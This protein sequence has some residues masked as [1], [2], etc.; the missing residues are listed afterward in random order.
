[1]TNAEYLIAIDKR[2]SRR[3]FK[4][5]ALDDD[6]KQLISELVDYVNEKAG[7]DFVFIDDARFAFNL[8][9]GMMSLIAV[10]G[11]D[12]IPA[13]QACGYYGET[14]VLQCAYHGIG[15]CWVGSYNEN[16]VLE[17]LDLPKGH[18][19]YCVIA[20]GNVSEKLSIK[21]K[22]IYSATHKNSKPYQK[23]FEFCDEKIT[24]EIVYAMQQVEKAP[25]S[26][27][28][29][30]VKFRYENG[31]VSAYVDEPYSDK[32][33]DFGIAQLHFQIGMS[34]KGVKG[35][36]EDG[37]FVA[38]TGRILKFPNAENSRNGVD[39]GNE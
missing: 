8:Q 32:S 4:P 29:R 11:P 15:T 26:V 9:S 18:R 20:V 37:R 3:A 1:M 6:V 7:L 22:M 14:I 19:L 30:P 10:C 25:S 2:R 5:R 12:T 34:A 31:V 36:W 28:R 39:N 27:N 33:I 38:D 13:R 16:K 24:P 17:K 35:R 23:M 21:E